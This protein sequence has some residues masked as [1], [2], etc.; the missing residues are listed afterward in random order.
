MAD[1]QGPGPGGVGTLPPQAPTEQAGGVQAPGATA[2]MGGP[3]ATPQPKMGEQMKAKASIEM[4]IKVLGMSQAA[5]EPMGEEAKAVRKALD[6]L[7][8]AFG[9]TAHDAK[10]LVPTE[11]AQLMQGMKPPQGAPPAGGQPGAPPPGA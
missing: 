10:D 9:G 5:F 3:M 1:V 2:P 8:K 7:A 11:I 4:A 6:I